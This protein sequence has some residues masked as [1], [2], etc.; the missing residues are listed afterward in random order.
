M[1]SNDVAQRLKV[2]MKQ[3][4]SSVG[5]F[6]IACEM[7]IAQ[8]SN[9]LNGFTNVGTKMQDTLRT[10]GCDIEWLMTGNKKEEIEILDIVLAKIPVYE[11]VRAGSK[12]GVLKE[13]ASDYVYTKKSPDQ[14]RYGV[15]VKGNS[16]HPEIREGEIVIVSKHAT[17][18]DGDICIVTFEDD[19]TCL[20]R[21]YFFD[22]SCQLVSDNVSYPP[23]IHKKKEIKFIHKV[24]EKIT[25]YT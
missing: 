1:K 10:L 13:E 21:V 12:C 5:E 14:S 15:R 6:A 19:E 3:H 17:V 8:A 7:S 4:Y 2:W 22:H 18:K 25:R 24:V 23:Q 9:Y 11:F 20:R 16:M